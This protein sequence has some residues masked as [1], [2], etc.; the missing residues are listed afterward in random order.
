[1]IEHYGPLTLFVLGSLAL[2]K[3]A[4]LMAIKSRSLAVDE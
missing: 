2:Y 4:F 3:V 1:M